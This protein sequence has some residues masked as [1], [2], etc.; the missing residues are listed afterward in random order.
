MAKQFERKST[1]LT[2][3]EYYENYRDRKYRFDT[4]YQRNSSIWSEDK[5]SFLIDSI[6]KNYPMPA[7]FLRPL[8]GEDGRTSYDVVDGKQRLQTI[9][10]FIEGDVPLT[11][12]F[13]EDAFI[14]GSDRFVA[15]R[16]SGLT[17]SEI[18]QSEEFSS[19]VRQFWN[20]TINVEL[21]YEEDEDLI[22]SVF[23]RLN[24]NGEPLTKQEL[25]KARYSK[26]QLWQTITAA[27]ECGFFADK[28][29]RLN[30]QRM[31]DLEFISELY[32]LIIEG[33]LL[34]STPD[35]LDSLYEKYN[36]DTVRIAQAENFFQ[37]I[38]E[39]LSSWDLGFEYNKRM[40]GTTH[41]YSIFSLAWHLVK[42]DDTD[43]SIGNKV[44]E[45][46]KSYFSQCHGDNIDNYRKACSSRTKSASSRR[47]RLEALLL[48]CCGRAIAD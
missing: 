22:A 18:R 3:S 48:Y 31:E 29:K 32:F 26:S 16:I 24:R 8:V 33:R 27:D 45:F 38:C 28:L 11:D 9:V 46:Y 41:L 47:D 30:S 37:R 19:Y 36:N 13:A 1:N 39:L 2:I 7:V 21:L 10:K 12:S 6:L 25:R 35:V 4:S 17:F 40:Y 43:S 23:D 5:C 42:T 14:D 34:D 44:N 15:E 20:Y